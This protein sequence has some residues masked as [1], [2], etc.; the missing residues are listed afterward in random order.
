[1]LVILIEVVN[2]FL[3]LSVSGGVYTNR[4]VNVLEGSFALNLIIL[5]TVTYIVNV[6]AGGQHFI[7]DFTWNASV[8]VAL[9]TFIGILAFQLANVTGITQYLKRK[10][11]AL[12][13]AIRNRAEAAPKPPT[14]TL[15]HRLTN[16]QEYELTLQGHA[17]AS[18]PTE[19]GDD[20]AQEPV[21]TAWYD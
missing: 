8:F 6:P 4:Y 16:P 10:C 12:K 3:W 7:V 17:T 9:A 11:A 18:E 5:T 1:M 21:Y 13:L 20:E 14:G 15:P 19:G 2:L